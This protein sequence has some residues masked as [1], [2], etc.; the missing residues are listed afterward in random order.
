M[1]T[2]RNQ[3][4]RETGR[5]IV[6]VILGILTGIMGG[7]WTSF[8][9]EWYKSIAPTQNPDWTVQFV[10]ATIIMIVFIAGLIYY[11]NRLLKH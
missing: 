1:T 2:E 6:G 4:R 10:G 3:L 5:F 11:A 9:I 8:F 7:I